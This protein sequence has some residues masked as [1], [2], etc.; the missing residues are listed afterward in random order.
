[1]P[2]SLAQSLFRKLQKLRLQNF[3]NCDQNIKIFF[4]ALVALCYVDINYINDTFVS[5]KNDQNFLCVNEFY[6]Y[7]Y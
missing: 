1:M 3:Y 4:K 6:Q 2:I 5:L 7:F